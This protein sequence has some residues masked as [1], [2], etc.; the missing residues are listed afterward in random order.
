MANII[1][2]AVGSVLRPLGFVDVSQGLQQ[3]QS[4]LNRYF[5][6]VGLSLY[7]PSDWK[8]GDYVDNGYADNSTLYSVVNR[9]MRTAAMAPFKVY[10]VKDQAK[11][12]KY[13]AFTGSNATAESLQHALRIKSLTYEEDTSHDLNKLIEKP[14]KYQGGNE[15]MQQS[16]GYKLLTG[17]RLWFK[18]VLDAGANAGKPFGVYNLPPQCASIIAG[19][20]MYDI[21]AYEFQMVI[22][23]RVEPQYIIHSR[24]PSFQFDG[25]GSHLWGMAPLQS[26]RRMLDRSSKAE[27]RAVTLLDK[28]GAAGILFNKST[29]AKEIDPVKE[30]KLKYKLNS[31]ILGSDNAAAIAIANGDLGYINFGQTAVDMDIVNQERYTDEKICNIFHAPPGLFMASANATDNN[32]KAW[33]KQ[34][35]TQAVIPELSSL[36][37]DWNE[38][39]K[40]Y[41][42]NNLYVD[43]SLECYPELLEDMNQLA[44]RLD[45]M[46]YYTGQEKRLM[47]GGDEDPNEP[48]LNKYFITNNMREIS[49]A[50]PNILQDEI[51]RIDPV[52]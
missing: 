40:L 27:R 34:L 35:I 13:K 42:D 45:K 28:A 19:N 46:W 14:N 43:Y 47:T 3:A 33:M 37:D 11:H 49:D 10:R 32:I 26:G 50:N 6:A 29:T 8:M 17:N 5:R 51:D 15:F 4:S 25:S 36:R 44:A 23:A 21:I 38:I 52:V 7:S 12:L 18:E 1:R 22:N 31:E 39:A 24:Y 2:K 41:K 16:I 30:G 48:M 20:V 9:I